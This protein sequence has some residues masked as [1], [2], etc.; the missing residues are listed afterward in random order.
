MGWYLV[1]VNLWLTGGLMFSDAA[2]F[3]Y[4]T[5]GSYGLTN[6]YIVLA[7]QV[8]GGS[9]EGVAAVM[10]LAALAVVPIALGICLLLAR[11]GAR[12]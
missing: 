3:E 9:L 2:R 7:E 11:R 1:G 4:S 5:N 8:V 6:D 12:S 10:S